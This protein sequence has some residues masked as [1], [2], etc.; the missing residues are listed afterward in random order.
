MDLHQAFRPSVILSETHFPFLGQDDVFADAIQRIGDEGFFQNIEIVNIDNVKQRRRIATL[1]EA[2]SLSMTYWS[3]LYCFV[4]KLSL[5][6]TDEALRKT[7]IAKMKDHMEQADEC[8]AQTF[9]VGSGPDPGQDLR[10]AATE[11]FY[12][13]L[14]ELCEAA[15]Q[16]PNMRVIIEPMDREAHKNCLIGPTAEFVKLI[17]RVRED[18]ANIG[19]CWDSAHVALCGDDIWESLKASKDIVFQM[20]LSNAILDRNDPGFGDNHM[21]TGKPG[22]L[23]VEKIAE[24][25]SL[26]AKSN[27]FSPESLSI[28]IEARTT[29]GSDPWATVRQSGEILIKAWAMYKAPGAG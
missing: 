18:Y 8:G 29:K 20:H 12:I 21:A 15:T 10:E 24:L 13:S 1:L 22:F 3:T 19:I 23:T 4:H 17:S 14:C 7:T 16:F 27:L 28:A 6:A 9:A 26:A 2:N 11:Q 25:F 5:S